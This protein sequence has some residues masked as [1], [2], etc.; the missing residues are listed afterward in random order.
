MPSLPAPASWSWRAARAWNNPPGRVD[1]L[2]ES[3]RW[4][5]ES[6]SVDAPELAERIGTSVHKTRK[7]MG[8]Y[9]QP[10]NARRSSNTLSAVKPAASL[11]PASSFSWYRPKRS[12]RSSRGL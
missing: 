8:G 9:T 4:V 6:V 12:H 10:P 2:T 1:A 3:T 7:D 5:G 11:S